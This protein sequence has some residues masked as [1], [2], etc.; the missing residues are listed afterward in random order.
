MDGWL[1]AEAGRSND[2]V[3]AF[4]EAR[5]IADLWLARMSLGMAYVQAGAYAEA[6][7]EFDV[8]QRRR[9]EAMA[10]YLDD[11][12]TARYLAPLPTG[13][14]ARRKGSANAPPRWRAT[15]NT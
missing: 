12:P 13:W 10:V 7:S 11:V 8:C 4:L 1:A 9:G 14:D 3:T 2:A 15:A 6:L 5:K